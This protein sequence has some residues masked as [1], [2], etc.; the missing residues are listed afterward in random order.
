[1]GSRMNRKLQENFRMN[2]EITK[3]R[4]NKLG[5]KSLQ[6]LTWKGCRGNFTYS[7]RKNLTCPELL[8]L[9]MDN[10]HEAWVTGYICTSTV[11]I[12]LLVHTTKMHKVRPLT[13]IKLKLNL[14]VVV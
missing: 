14:K 2:G 1:M 4:W 6:L 5:L 7:E 11:K 8:Q 13:N 10:R 9:Y 3:V 12:P